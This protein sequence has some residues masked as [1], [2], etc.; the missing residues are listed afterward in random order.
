MLCDPDTLEDDTVCPLPLGPLCTFGGAF[1][2]GELSR[3]GHIGDMYAT[4]LSSLFLRLTSHRP[5]AII[6]KI[7]PLSQ[8]DPSISYSY[9]NG[10]KVHEIIVPCRMVEDAT[11]YRFID[12]EAAFPRACRL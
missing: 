5:D 6:L 2:Y 4:Q 12:T 7:D 11:G 1:T 9:S 3:R 10:R 8:D